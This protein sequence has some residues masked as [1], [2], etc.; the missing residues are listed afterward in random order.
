MDR[1]QKYAGKY[2]EG[3]RA[4]FQKGHLAEN[5]PGNT[6]GLANN[7]A[8]EYAEIRRA[9]MPRIFQNI[10]NPVMV[11]HSGGCGANRSMCPVW[12]SADASN[13]WSPENT[14]KIVFK[15][16]PDFC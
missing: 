11:V 5:T 12:L 4:R 14:P 1:P 2:A 3:R 7:Y 8:R 10:G 16:T 15:N 9:N 6:P 13:A